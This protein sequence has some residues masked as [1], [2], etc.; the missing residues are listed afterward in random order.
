MATKRRKTARRR[1]TRRRSHRRSIGLARRNPPRSGIVGTLTQGVKDAGLVLAGKAATNFASRMVP[2]TSAAMG[3][4]TRVAAA[5]GV[6]LLAR[7]FMGADSARLVIAGGLVAPIENAIK[8]AN[9]PLLSGA[10]ASD[11]EIGAY[12]DGVG[13][14]LEAGTNRL[15]GGAGI[16]GVGDSSGNILNDAAYIAA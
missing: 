2:T 3:V 12:Y 13:S 1:S 16:N 14:Y 6:G 7:R 5:L 11:E 10:L 8:A 9:V 15:Q 4:A